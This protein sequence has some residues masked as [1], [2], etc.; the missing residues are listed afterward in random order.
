MKVLAISNQKFAGQE[1]LINGYSRKFLEQTYR[2]MV[3]NLSSITQREC[4]D[5]ILCIARLKNPNL[6][7]DSKAFE[8]ERLRVV[9]DLLSK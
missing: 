4:Y 9:A 2:K 7:V 8:T 1:Q 3:G 5:N 6:K